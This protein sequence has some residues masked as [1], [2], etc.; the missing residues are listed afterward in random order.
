M[1]TLK[2]GEADQTFV[3][4]LVLVVFTAALVVFVHATK[5]LLLLAF[6]AMLGSVL[7]SAIADSVAKRTQ[8]PRAAGLAIAVLGFLATLLLMGWLFGEETATQA[9]QLRGTLPQDWMKL[10]TRLGADPMGRMLLGSLHQDVGGAGLA[11]RL[12]DY[13]AGAVEIAI[14]FIIIII[15]AIFF[16][17]QPA[18]YRD[19]LV[20]LVPPSYRP[21][22][23]LAADD[24]GRALK[25]WLLTQLASMVLMGVMIGV[26]LWWSGVQAPVALGLLGG[27]SEFI[28]YVGPTLAMVPAV[29]VAVAGPGSLAGVLLTYLVVRIVQANVITPL[30]T[31]RLVSIP[32]G[33]YLFMILSAGFALG[34]FGL[35]FAGALAVA[36]YTLTIR[37]YARET[38][39]DDVAPPGQSS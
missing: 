11:S 17:G 4:R 1:L 26:G 31:R 14:N 27:L 15:G 21:V 5:N 10:Q 9:E 25:L 6:G 30:I 12:M 39:G 36:T 35:F 18:L 32:P 37:L 22:A 20:K 33:L 19:G 16:A 8:L 29:I 23:C 24:V 3:R 34:T 7:F 2:P 28:P 13:G 38:L